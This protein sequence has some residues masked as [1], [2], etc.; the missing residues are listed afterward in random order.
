MNYLVENLKMI[1]SQKLLNSLTP[2]EIEELRLEIF[3]FIEANE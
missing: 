1:D 3:K 2:V